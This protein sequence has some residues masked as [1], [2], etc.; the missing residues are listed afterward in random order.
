MRI[1]KALPKDVPA[2]AALEAEI[3]SDPWTALTIEN[4][5]ADF[6]VA[7][8]DDGAIAG[9][10]CLSHVLDEGSID[11]IATAPDH[12]RQGVADALLANAFDEAKT[13]ELAFL[14][15]E[16]RASNEAAIALYTKHGYERVGLRRG[17]YSHPKEDA[18]LM[19]RFT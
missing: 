4:H 14:T 11:I 19:T 3:F 16:V 5:L 9:Y 7:R 18:I 2:L 13:L 12:R 8:T 17:Y 6:T 1:E 15:L 10:Y